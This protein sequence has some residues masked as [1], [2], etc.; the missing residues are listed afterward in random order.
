MAFNVG[1][2]V[3]HET[4]GPVM[5]IYALARDPRTDEPYVYHCEWFAD[6]KIQRDSFDPKVLV[7]VT[8]TG[9]STCSND[10]R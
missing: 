10:S 9:D 2:K 4:G 1:D 5:A 6:G 7:S 3:K 8:D